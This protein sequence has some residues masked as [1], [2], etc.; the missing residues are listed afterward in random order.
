[1][2]TAP[3]PPTPSPSSSSGSGSG[4]ADW[5]GNLINWFLFTVVGSIVMMFGM[6]LALF[7]Q[8]DWAY[9]TLVGFNWIPAAATG[10]VAL[11]FN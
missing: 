4:G 1:M 10:S 5:F 3:P 7:G 8:W 6:V 9:T 11:T 2:W